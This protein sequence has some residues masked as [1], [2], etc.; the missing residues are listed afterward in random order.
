MKKLIDFKAVGNLC[1]KRMQVHGQIAQVKM[2]FSERLCLV[3]Y[4]VYQSL[5]LIQLWDL[6][7]DGQY[8]KDKISK[9]SLK[10]LLP[11]GCSYPSM[12]TTV[13]SLFPS[14]PCGSS[15]FS[16]LACAF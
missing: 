13:F 16:R 7:S 12:K 5:L 8:L 10:P 14:P 9:K 6:L 15:V 4:H 3:V 1:L 2:R 11:G